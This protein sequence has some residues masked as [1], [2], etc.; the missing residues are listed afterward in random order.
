MAKKKP[1][2]VKE[3]FDRAK[4]VGTVTWMA[5]ETTTQEK[6]GTSNQNLTGTL[7]ILG[8]LGTINAMGKHQ[9]EKAC[10]PVLRRF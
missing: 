5:L 2:A 7:F 3:P 9:Q 8:A 6:D 1:V 10:W 4:H